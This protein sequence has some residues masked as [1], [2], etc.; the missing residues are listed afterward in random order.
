ATSCNAPAQKEFDRSVALLHSFQFSK[1]IDGFHAALKADAACGIAYWGIALSQWSNPFATGMKERSQ[2][3]AGRQSVSLGPSRGAKTKGVC[4]SIAAVAA[5]YG[6]FETATQA[7]RL[8]AYREAMSR[9]AKK[10]PTDQ[11][12][13]IFYALSITAAEDLSD[14][15]YAG[16]LKA[17]TILEEL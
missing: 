16:R 15:T 7:A 2:L 9:V 3:Q 8:I 17:G 11:E 1:A 13:Q 12:A 4:N 5:L 6:D 14:K 10:Y